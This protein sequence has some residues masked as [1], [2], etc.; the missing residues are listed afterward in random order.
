MVCLFEQPILLLSW[1][2]FTS[3][4]MMWWRS[5]EKGTNEEWRVR[6]RKYGTVFKARNR[7]T[8][9]YVAIRKTQLVK[10]DDS[11]QRNVGLLRKNDC[12]HIAKCFGVIAEEDTLWVGIWVC[13]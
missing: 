3:K 13:V 7:S 6:R 12:P 11:V 8:G 10:N 5:W 9:A 1:T 4:I 2:L